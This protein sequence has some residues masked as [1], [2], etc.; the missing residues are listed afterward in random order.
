MLESF[1]ITNGAYDLDKK[2]YWFEID[3]NYNFV[4]IGIETGVN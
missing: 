2:E 3:M 4:F 1:S